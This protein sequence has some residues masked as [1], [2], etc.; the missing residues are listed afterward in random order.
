MMLRQAVTGR[1]TGQAG[2]QYIGQKQG[3]FT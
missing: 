3:W 2:T 1:I